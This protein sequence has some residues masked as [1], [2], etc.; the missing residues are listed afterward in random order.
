MKIRIANDYTTPDGQTLKAG[1][2]HDL[3]NADARNLIHRGKAAELSPGQK[4]AAT[5]AAKA[6]GKQSATAESSSAAA[7]TQTPA[8][9]QGKE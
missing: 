2:I 8:G 1:S 9:E 6:K 7:E 5:R 4:A 3:D